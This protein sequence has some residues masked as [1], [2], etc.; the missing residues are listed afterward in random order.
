M[1]PI[2]MKVRQRIIAMYDEGEP[3]KE[4]AEALGYC[5]AA[6]RR[7]KQHLRERK[8]LEP[9]VPERRGPKGKLTPELRE[10]LR[11]LVAATP[12]ATLEELRDDDKD[13]G[14]GGGAAPRV[15]VSTSTVDRWLGKLKLPL[16]KSR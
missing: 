4:I 14:G 12:D 5:P 15:E 6:V 11:R 2:P 7:V 3:T 16:K 8:T 13:G 9:K 10:R 1:E